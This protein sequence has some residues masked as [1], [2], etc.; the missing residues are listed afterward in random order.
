MQEEGSVSWKRILVAVIVVVAAL[1]SAVWVIVATYDYNKLKP[2]LESAFKDA[3][4]RDLRLRGNLDLKIGLTPT[5]VVSSAAVQNAPW[6]SRPEM[7]EIKRFEVQLALIPLVL[8]RVDVKRI[9]LA[10]PDILIETNP[11][12][13]SNLDFLKKISGESARKE[14]PSA[15]KVKLTV[16][17][18]EI[19]DGRLTYRDGKTGKVY[20]VT[21][22]RF[23]A[24]ARGADSP[25]RVRLSGFYHHNA[26][27]VQGSIVPIAG[28]TNATRPWPFNLIVGFAGTSISLDG[29]IKDVT[30]LQGA[31]VK[32][33]VKSKDAARLGELLDEPSPL[34]GPLEMSCRITDPRPKAYEVADVKL[35]AGG[36]DLGGS[37]G[38]DLS[39]PRPALTADLRSRRL[40]LRPLAG[41]EKASSKT[42]ATRDRIFPDSPLPLGPLRLADATVSLR[43]AEVFTPQLVLHDLDAKVALVD[44]RLSVRPL[45]AI[46]GGGR[47]DVGRFDL[48]SRGKAARV[49]TVVTVRQ[50]DVGAMQREIK[51]TVIVE[52]RLDAHV[53]VS[54]TGESMASLLSGLSGMTYVIMGEG[55]INNRY[56]GILGSNQSFEYP[57]YD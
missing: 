57:P 34:Q 31:D 40:D 48:D 53:D 8:H 18:M 56:L 28:F 36:S 29:T 20:V 16:N 4:G 13:E 25:L 42:E 27:E 10:S 54:G 7:A 50:L 6:G 37:L 5:L 15:E 52:G 55:R 43:A 33:V 21:L 47:L 1:I 23:G 44:G 30:N 11:A 45:T 17:E 39:K 51:K 32:V 3:T 14:K 38:L 41:K 35:F 12:G 9:V 46:I 2:Q 49:K 19:E 24:S 22:A 26:F